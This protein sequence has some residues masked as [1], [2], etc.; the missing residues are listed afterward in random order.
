MGVPPMDLGSR[1][2]CPCYIAGPVDA[3]PETKIGCV[4]IFLDCH[5]TN[6][7]VGV[8]VPDSLFV[9]DLIRY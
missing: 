2:R 9:K 3:A 7:I 5:Y 6:V 1:A 8:I 4:I